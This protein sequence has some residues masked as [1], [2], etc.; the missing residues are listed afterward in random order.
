MA[1]R[2]AG[3]LGGL[4]AAG[5]AARSNQYVQRLV[6][7]PELRNNLAAALAAA[8]KAYKRLQNGRAPARAL[9]EDRKLQRQLREAANALQQAGEGL[10]GKRRRRR[11]VR[12]L[13]LL[14]VGAGLA[15]A[16]SEGA[17]KKV[18]DLVFGA[19]EEFEYKGT[20][21]PGASTN[22][23]GAASSTEAGTSAQSTVSGG[24]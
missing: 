6:E 11:G 4:V 22:G 24:E 3:R 23:A 17:R 15:L 16:L 9:L 7:D 5:K 13:G 8:R 2:S 19:E 10:R 18:L 14:V 1:R 21:T 12:T 20:T